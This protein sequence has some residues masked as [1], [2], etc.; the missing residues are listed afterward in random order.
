MRILP[1]LFTTIALSACSKKQEDV[2]AGRTEKAVASGSAAVPVGAPPASTG[3]G[4]G[5]S[6]GSGTGSGAGSASDEAQEAEQDR[7]DQAKMDAINPAEEAERE[8]IVDEI[9]KD[10]LK[11]ERANGVADARAFLRR[12]AR[13]T[14]KL[15]KVLHGSEAVTYIDGM[16]GT[17]SATDRGVCG[18]APELY[19]DLLA[20]RPILAAAGRRDGVGCEAVDTD[21]VRCH[22]S[23]RRDGDPEYWF[24]FEIVR[25]DSEVAH[26]N[27]FA[28]VVF[29]G[30]DP[31]FY[32]RLKTLLSK[33]PQKRCPD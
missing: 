16:G 13:G 31:V 8:A 26:L 28:K 20:L 33:T 25:D 6:T 3:S 10:E 4:T 17:Q 14:L 11:T 23:P 29:K 5:S 15:K 30:P 21:L 22:L 27:G 1:I 18:D 7:I 2:P 9:H 19:A 24:S 12:L 32:E